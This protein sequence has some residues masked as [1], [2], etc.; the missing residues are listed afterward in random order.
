[1]YTSSFPN[2]SKVPSKIFMEFVICDFPS[3]TDPPTA[4]ASAPNLSGCLVPCSLP[5]PSQIIPQVL[6]E[7]YEPSNHG[8][9]QISSGGL[10][11]GSTLEKNM[12]LHCDCW[13][14]Y[15]TK[16][17]SWAR[18]RYE[19]D[20]IIDYSIRIATY[21]FESYT[22]AKHWHPAKMGQVQNTDFG[23][24][25]WEVQYRATESN[26]VTIASNQCKSKITVR[27][28]KSN[29]YSNSLSRKNLSS[30][31][32]HLQDM[33]YTLVIQEHQS[34]MINGEVVRGHL[35]NT[36]HAFLHPWHLQIA[37]QC[38]MFLQ[39]QNHHWMATGT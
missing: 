9:K 21:S 18:T 29:S 39:P 20:T 14:I 2:I 5:L 10:Q 7:P 23:W 1:M 28:C 32:F 8:W 34:D 4:T 11:H 27:S 30:F 31:R 16:G 22:P 24:W 33:T 15:V 37:L 25:G 19:Y 36:P 13:E 17:K 6:V 3:P 38:L 35:S 26:Y 12:W